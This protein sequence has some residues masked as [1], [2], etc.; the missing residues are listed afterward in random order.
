MP[1]YKQLLE[2][3]QKNKSPEEIH[4]IMPMRPSHWRRML[5]GKRFRDALQTQE[6]I[7]AAIATHRIAA[8]TNEATDRLVELMQSQNAETAR[9]ACM[10]L[11]SEGLRITA[12]ADERADEKAATRPSEVTAP[13]KLL[14]PLEGQDQTTEQIEQGDEMTQRLS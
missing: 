2:L 1:S 8:G 12:E 7:A 6:D 9:K 3:I 13:W 14:R 10:S 4:R 5:W 11:L